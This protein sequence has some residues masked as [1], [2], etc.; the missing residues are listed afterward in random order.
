MKLSVFEEIKIRWVVLKANTM[1]TM[2]ESLAYSLNNWGGLASTVVYMLT[3]LI[4]LSAIFGK[5]KLVAGYNYGE[6]LF[7]TLVGQFNFYLSWIW[8][9][10]NIDRLGEDV[11]SG[12]LDL[13]LTKPLPALWQV[14][15]QKV[16]L[17]MLLFEMWPATIPL[18]YLVFKNGNYVISLRGFLLGIVVFVTGHIAIHCFQFVIGLAVF[19]LGDYG[20]ANGLSYQIAFFGTSI[21]F[22]AYPKVFMSLGL[23]VAPFLLHTALTTSILLGKTTDIR[24][25]WLSVVVMVAFLIIK[26]KAWKLALRQYSSASS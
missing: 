22:E 10:T 13:I 4:F 12:R 21:P 16:N 6:I 20:G 7:M 17:F 8:S 5:V 2:K 1:F 15:F 3:Y 19:W 24:F 26:N 25:V 18:I 11:K 23:T 14:T 9:V